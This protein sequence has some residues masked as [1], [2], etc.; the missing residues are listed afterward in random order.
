MEQKNIEKAIKLSV[1]GG[2]KDV[3]I[4]DGHIVYYNACCNDDIFLDPEFW[5]CLG[6]SLGWKDDKPSQTFTT[7]F[8]EISSK[9]LYRGYLSYW[10]HFIDHLAEGKDPDSFFAELLK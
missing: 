4:K 9:V 7:E 5:K 2:Y 6:K 8:G 1:D 10:H 3:A